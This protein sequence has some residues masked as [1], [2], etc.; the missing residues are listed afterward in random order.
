MPNPERP[1][2][3]PF[4]AAITSVITANVAL[5]GPPTVTFTRTGAWEGGFGG[6]LTIR[7]DDPS[8]ITDWRV[9][10]DGGP[11][12]T[13][14]WN[15]TYSVSQGR[16]T[17]VNAG[18]NGTIAPGGSV[19]AGFNGTG[20]FTQNIASC[21]VNGTA[22][23]VEYAG[24]PGGG[25]GG[26]GG[27]GDDGGDGGGTTGGVRPRGPFA[28]PSDLNGD[29]STDGSDLGV[30]LGAWGTGAQTPA[31]LNGDGSVDGVDLGA[32]LGG[33]GACP[34]QRRVVAYWIEWGIYGRNYQPADTPFE[35]ITHLNYAFADI[36]ADGRVVPFD[37][38][39]AIEKI[40]PGDAWDQPIKGAYNQINNV[41]KRQHPHLKTLI[42][43]GGW[44][45]SGR[46][47]D[48]ALTA[49][50]RAVF[51]QS[52]VEFLRT[53]GFDGIDIDWEYPV[54]GG[55]E[56]NTYRPEDR[57]NFTL[58]MR[59]VRAALQAA[60][61][62][63]GREYLLTI[64]APAGY[65]KFANMDAA[66]YAQHLD[67][68]NVMT[69]DYFGAWDLSF[70]ANHAMFE[71]N[72][73]IPSAN[74]ELRTKY[75]TKFAI[76]QYLDAGVPAEKLVLGIPFYGRGWKGVPAA[77]GGLF[78]SGTGVPPGTWDDWSSG[79]TGVSDFTQIDREFLAA[80]SGYTRGWD[81]VSKSPFVYSPT[82]FGGHWVGYEDEESIAIKLQWAE[83]I[84]LGGAM[85]WEI[86]ADRDQKLLDAILRGLGAR[87]PG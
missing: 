8:P 68:I 50:S 65:D 39:A 48:V 2:H 80:G 40:Y 28:C 22:A 47:S 81:P 29:G 69:Y 33:W 11:T 57:Q 73:G 86:T 18:W 45:L 53:Y 83:S 27:G 56:S 72:P 1:V 87:S 14:L 30:L 37:R 63:D 6:S 64:A 76:Q 17:V 25:G 51:A 38:Y 19:T 77:N 79:A 12:I 75:N 5:A 46:F 32:L 74:P 10:W 52:C 58:L 16:S 78:Q 36:G 54:A 3:L 35:K 23:V 44:T 82:A 55:L 21:T 4:L 13:T 20:V 7:N 26:S 9:S 49:S 60:G 70:T 84:G 67:F 24:F 34:E 15:G 66:S 61:T 71:A 85:F 62:A 41:L 43:V 31:D 42:S 59:D